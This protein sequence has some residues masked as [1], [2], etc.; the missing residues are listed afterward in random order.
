[1]KRKECVNR[2]LSR[3]SL[4]PNFVRDSKFA[5]SASESSLGE[6]TTKNQK[7]GGSLLRVAK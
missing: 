7:R 3:K 4:S 5:R 2:F 1:M 6:T